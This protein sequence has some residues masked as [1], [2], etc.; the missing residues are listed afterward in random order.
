MVF[1]DRPIASRIPG[2]LPHISSG[3]NSIGG[4]LYLV[5]GLTVLICGCTTADATPVSRDPSIAEQMVNDRVSLEVVDGEREAI[6]N[7][8][9]TTSIPLPN[10]TSGLL[11]PTLSSSIS[12]KSFLG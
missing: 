9:G 3:F 8:F 11:V 12:I 7:E 5:S 1:M 10:V 6:L 2:V 4:Y